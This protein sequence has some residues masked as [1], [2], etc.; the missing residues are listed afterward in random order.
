MQDILYPHLGNV[1]CNREEEDSVLCVT[2]LVRQ[3]VHYPHLGNVVIEKRKAV[4]MCNRSSY[5]GHPL[6]SPWEC[7]YREEE[8]SVYV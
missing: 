6:L 3:D 5:T 2:G 8:G 4:S 1:V 7:C